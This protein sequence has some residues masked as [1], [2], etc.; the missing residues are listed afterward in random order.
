M[1]KRGPKPKPEDEKRTHLLTIR[2]TSQESEALASLAPERK[3]ARTIGE[4]ILK[5]AKR[6][7]GGGRFTV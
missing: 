2:L 1:A 4:L 7:C 5:A 3:R 6:R